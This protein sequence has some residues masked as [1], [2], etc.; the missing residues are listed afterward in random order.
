[1]LIFGTQ[2]IPS[3]DYLSFIGQ[4]TMSNC[5]PDRPFLVIKTGSTMPDLKARRGDF[6]DWILQG[7][8][9]SPD[10]AWVVDVSEGEALP[11]YHE[12][13]GLAITGSHA[14][15]TEQRDWSE[16]T[17]EWLATAAAKQI[18]TLGIC[19]GHQLLAHCLGG[20]VDWNPK[21]REV[22]T[23]DVT[24]HPTAQDDPLFA[25]L[26]NSISVNLSHRQAVL[27]LPPDVT[28]L[29]SSAMADH[30]AF[31]YGENV[32]GLQFHPEFDRD[33]MQS[34]IRYAREGL[35]A[36][37]QDPDALLAQTQETPQG[38]QVMARFAALVS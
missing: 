2:F 22:G 10:R 32:W 25:D 21:G 37:S 31:R 14:M 38:L 24:L 9:I 4:T 33:V 23:I 28:L 12:I 18:P 30:I 34:Y 35:I 27:E 36:E 3:S 17:A 6:E 26:P 20:K 19:Y 1:L 13:C 29:A 11:H 5:L 7:L 16:A 15:V 8:D